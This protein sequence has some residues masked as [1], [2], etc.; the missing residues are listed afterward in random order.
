MDVGEAYRADWDRAIV[1][2]GYWHGSV[3]N[4][5][6]GF[7]YFDP[8]EGLSYSE[9]AYR[10]V[11]ARGVEVLADVSVETFSFDEDVVVITPQTSRFLVRRSS[12]WATL[13][14]VP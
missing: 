13:E 12:H 10:I 9:E 4:S 1:I 3:A 6:L 5:Q 11:F 14:R 8:D 2:G 7:E